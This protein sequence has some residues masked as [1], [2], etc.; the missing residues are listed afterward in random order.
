[1]RKWTKQETKLRFIKAIYEDQGGN[2]IYFVGNAWILGK[3]PKS[4]Y[5]GQ[6]VLQGEIE[7]EGIE[8]EEVDKA[9][10]KA[11]ELLSK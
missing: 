11:N 4:N 6:H 10:E 5:R 2:R 8:L 1:M 3:A 7:L 9:I